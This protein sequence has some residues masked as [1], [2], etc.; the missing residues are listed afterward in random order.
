MDT[1]MIG[2]KIAKARKEKNMSQ[3]ELARLLFISPQAVG[4]WERGESVPDIVTIN[5]LAEILGVDLNYFSENFQSTDG[6][7]A[8]K[9]TIDSNSD[10][11]HTEPEVENLSRSPER[12]MH[13]N[14]SGSNLSKSDFAGVT[15]HKRKFNGSALRGSDFAGA[16]LTGSSFTGSDVREAN[17]DGANLT[18]CTLSANSLTDASFNKTILVR[19]EFSASEL[20]GAKFT[21]TELIDVKLT[22][23]DLRKTI[24][25]NCIFNGVDFKYSD[26]R[27]LC[28]DGQTFIG[29]KFDKA[30]LNEA[31]FNGATLK[32]V[33]FRPTF[34]LT[35]K[36]YRALKT[37]C[38]DGAMMDKLTYAVLKGMGADLS[39]VTTI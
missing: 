14:F 15:A 32:N 39:K 23:T 28:L 11:E 16:D 34:A 38:F 29:V 18:D 19:T 3:A 26:L 13:T 31:T 10:I 36:Y 37:I 30:A 27:G 24:F 25:K 4:K 21:S 9:M 17:F 35:N 2:S 6:E 33:S 22:K 1:K 8:V 5:R 12:Q 7:T 20:T